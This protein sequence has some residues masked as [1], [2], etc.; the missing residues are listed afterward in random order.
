M[1]DGVIADF[2]LVEQMLKY[3]ISKVQRYP[4]FILRPRAVIGVPSGITEVEKRAVV[5][6]AESAGVREVYLVAEPMSSAIGMGIPVNEPSGNMIIDI[7]DGTAEIAV[8]ALDGH[9]LR[10]VGA[11]RRRR[12][13]RGDRSYLKK[14]YN[15]LVGGKHRRTD[16]NS[17]GFRLPARGRA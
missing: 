3:L 4:S 16:Q 5:D 12:N 17:G 15:L 10:H 11:G 7:G 6:S 1:K 8:I 9:G 14:T 13:G 2:E